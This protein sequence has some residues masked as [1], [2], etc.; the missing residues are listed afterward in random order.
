MPNAKTKLIFEGEFARLL[1][2]LTLSMVARRV[3]KS[4]GHVRSCELYGC[5]YGTARA[6]SATTG[7]RME[8]YLRPKKIAIPMT[9]YL[10]LAE[11]ASE[12]ESRS[13]HRAR[14][15]AR[16]GSQKKGQSRVK[17]ADCREITV[18][19]RRLDPAQVT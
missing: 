13:S 5:C 18:P 12:N 1:A 6:L 11:A 19:Q 3:G 7:A 14:V 4:S 2:G 10:A 15:T 17:S 9:E 16:T 8:A